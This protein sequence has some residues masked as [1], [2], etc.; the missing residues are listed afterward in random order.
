MKRVETLLNSRV[1]IALFV[2]A[3]KSSHSHVIV[4]ASAVPS[5]CTKQR[6]L[7]PYL[8]Y[9]SAEN[10]LAP[11]LMAFINLRTVKR[12]IGIWH[13]PLQSSVSFPLRPQILQIC[14]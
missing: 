3:A 10:V 13:F 8:I 14:N 2:P 4:L 6:V 7:S 1:L 12:L 11:L 9:A 5:A